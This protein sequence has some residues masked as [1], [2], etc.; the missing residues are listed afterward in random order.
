MKAFILFGVDVTGMGGR[1][2][3]EPKHPA[4]AESRCLALRVFPLLLLLRPSYE[5]STCLFS[6]DSN[7]VKSD[8]W[9]PWWAI[10]SAERGLH[11]Q[12]TV[13]C[14]FGWPSESPNLQF[15]KFLTH[16]KKTCHCSFWPVFQTYIFRDHFDW[17]WCQTWQMIYGKVPG[18]PW[19]CASPMAW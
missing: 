2:E 5:Q 15:H 16:N 13:C 18:I 19:V 12:T 10:N 8:E 17:T 3:V 11:Q 7:L 14:A 4:S 1:K 6:L 9:R